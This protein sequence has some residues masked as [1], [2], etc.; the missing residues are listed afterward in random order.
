[1]MAGLGF[2]IASARFL[3]TFLYIGFSSRADPNFLQF[4]PAGLSFLDPLQFFSPYL[5]TP[6]SI[7]SLLS[8]SG[9]QKYI[10]ILPILFLASALAFRGSDRMRKFFSFFLLFSLLA[11]IQ[12]SPFG[13]VF[14]FVPGLHLLTYPGRWMFIAYFAAAMLVAIGFDGFFANR[15]AGYLKRFEKIFWRVGL[16]IIFFLISGWVALFVFG[17]RVAAILKGYFDTRLYST[18]SY[19]LPIEHYHQYIE[20]VFYDSRSMFNIFSPKVFL[21]AAFFFISFIVVRKYRNGAWDPLF[22]SKVALVVVIANL[23]SVFAFFHILASPS[24]INEIPDTARHI[25]ELQ[26]AGG[27]RAM[28]FL[29]GQTEF[30]K[31]SVPSRNR[32]SVLSSTR[33]VNELLYPNVNLLYG[34]ESLDYFDNFM[35]RRGSRLIAYL[36]ATYPTAG[37]A[38]VSQDLLPEEKVRILETRKNLINFSGVQY[39]VSAYS[40]DES[41]FPKIF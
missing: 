4:A 21:P 10:G 38:L 7:H 40:L 28:P 17:S 31:L 12:Y 16:G 11:A 33:L 23:V 25:R 37:E 39:I 24:V 6:Y 9:E 35:S 14:Q 19:V 2:L 29:P 30:F 27:G 3:A 5:E 26:E 15:E 8:F 20:R 18:G 13:Y 41:R 32:P 34:V 1:M 36:G 22:S